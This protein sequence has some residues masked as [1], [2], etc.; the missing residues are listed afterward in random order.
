VLKLTSLG[1]LAAGVVVLWAAPL[2]FH[3]AFEGRYDDGL[4]VLPWTLTYCVWYALLIVAQN[5]IWCAERTKLGT[6]PLASGLIVNIALN[7]VLIPMW[8][9]LGAV[10]ATTVATGLAVGVLYAINRR[11]GMEIQSGLIWLSIAPVALGGGVWWGTAALVLLAAVVPFSRTLFTHSER[12]AL[13]QFI[14][15]RLSGVAALVRK[16]SK[17]AETKHAAS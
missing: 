14:Q 6:I 17:K 4:A 16:R 11:H 9:L 1:M 2:L 15:E 5:F 7:F 3:V 13:M 10:V 12:H 8:G